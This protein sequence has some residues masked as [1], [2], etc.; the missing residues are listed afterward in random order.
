M[1][2]HVFTLK[3]LVLRDFFLISS[4]HSNWRLVVL[5]ASLGVAL[6]FCQ[7]FHY[8]F[9]SNF[10]FLQQFSAVFLPL[11]GRGDLSIISHHSPRSPWSKCSGFHDYWEPVRDQCAALLSFSLWRLWYKILLFPEKQA[12]IGWCLDKTSI[13][14]WPLASFWVC[15]T[16]VIL[17]FHLLL[18]LEPI[19]RGVSSCVKRPFYRNAISIALQLRARATDWPKRKGWC[20]ALI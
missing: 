20:R 10:E 19:K 12:T 16:N 5:V 15:K 9:P 18:L 3:N 11:R 1:I 8:N 4:P 2:K 17:R 14:D 13:K 7:T 6:I